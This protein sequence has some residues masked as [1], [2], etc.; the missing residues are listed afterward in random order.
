MISGGDAFRGNTRSHPEHDG[1]DLSGQGYCIGDDMGEE[2]AAGFLWG[3]SSVGR[4]PAL[5]AGG[6]EFESL[7]LHLHIRAFCTLKTTY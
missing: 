5:Q 2:V 4:A 7:H 3:C 6:Q 1:E